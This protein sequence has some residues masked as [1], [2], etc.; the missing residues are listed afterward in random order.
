MVVGSLGYSYITY[1]KSVFFHPKSLYRTTLGHWFL[2]PL[3]ETHVLGMVLYFRF[4]LSDKAGVS[5]LGN[6]HLEKSVNIC[7]PRY[8]LT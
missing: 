4:G 6:G 2:A 7:G 5:H 1:R 8:E 3:H